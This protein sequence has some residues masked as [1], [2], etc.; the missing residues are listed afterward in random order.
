MRMSYRITEHEPRRYTTI[1][2]CGSR[3][4]RRAI[5][6]MQYEAVRGGSRITCQ[7]DFQ[8]RWLY[9]PLIV[10]LLLMQRSALRRDL[11]CLR[12]AL[13]EP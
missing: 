8:L 12:R 9:L 13:L 11:E 6:R 4:F 2:L 3:M 7:V 5:W 10:P 1:E